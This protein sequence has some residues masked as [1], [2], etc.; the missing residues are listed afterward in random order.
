MQ[1]TLTSKGQM[2]LPVAARARLGLE[3]GDH[4]L[5][6]VQ[7]DDTIILKRPPAASTASLRGLLAKPKRSLTVEEMDAGIA[8]HLAAKHRPGA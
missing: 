6:I 3:A 7:D 5:V 2:T 4:L 1:A 8:A